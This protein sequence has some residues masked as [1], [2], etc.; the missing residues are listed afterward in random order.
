MRGHNA[1]PDKQA[2]AL[3]LGPQ[4][5]PVLPECDHTV[6]SLTHPQE[7][8]LDGPGPQLPGLE[9]PRASDVAGMPGLD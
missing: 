8:R 7:T 5:H 2:I 6:V 4:C 1:N 3:L 9:G